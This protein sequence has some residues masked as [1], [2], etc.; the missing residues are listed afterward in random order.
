MG[1]QV[2]VRKIPRAEAAKQLNGNRFVAQDLNPGLAKNAS[3][4]YTSAALLPDVLRAYPM[5]FQIQPAKQHISNNLWPST[6]TPLV[7]TRGVF[8]DG[9]RFQKEV[10]KKLI[11]PGNA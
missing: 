5:D 9:Q 11:P 4:Q 1:H 2:R 6:K 8:V 3:A 10:G 7:F